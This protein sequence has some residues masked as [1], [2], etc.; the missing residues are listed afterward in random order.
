MSRTHTLKYRQASEKPSVAEP[1][2]SSPDTTP[3]DTA[4]SL[5]P[6]P[7]DIKTGATPRK[8]RV[9]R[10]D[11]GMYP[12]KELT[13]TQVV[14]IP[15]IGIT[16]GLTTK[17]ADKTAMYPGDYQTVESLMVSDEGVIIVNGK[18]RIP[19]AGG[20]VLGWQ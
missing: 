2:V 17:E 15:R 1:P 18:F 16:R 12:I 14:K 11:V 13:F 10:Q 7:E 9:E 4:P 8:S 20:S 6:S 19:I 3:T 5:S